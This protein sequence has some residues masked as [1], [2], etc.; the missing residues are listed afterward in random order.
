MALQPSTAQGIALKDVYGF[1]KNRRIDDNLL[2][3]S[4]RWDPRHLSTIEKYGES[5][6]ILTFPTMAELKAVLLEL[7]DVAS[8][9]IPAGYLGDRCPTLV[10]RKR[11]VPA[12]PSQ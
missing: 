11:A 12:T 4:T 2:I 8:I 7:F 3:S 5:D 9:S 6:T 1:W 10:L